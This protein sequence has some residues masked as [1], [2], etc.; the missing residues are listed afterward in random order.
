VLVHSLVGRP[1]NDILSWKVLM[2]TLDDFH[3]SGLELD[4]RGFQILCNGCEKALLASFKLSAEEQEDVLTSIQIVTQEFTQLS[5]AGEKVHP[6]IPTLLH[7]IEGVHLHAY[8][9]VLGF[10]KEHK[11]L[12]D[13]LR[14]MVQHNEALQKIANDTKNGW[15]LILRTIVA[16][17]VFLGRTE[18][19]AEAESLVNGVE[20][21][22]GWPED[23]AA[24]QYIDFRLQD[25]D[26]DKNEPADHERRSYEQD[27]DEPMSEER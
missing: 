19:E 7:S 24:E 10:A 21:W 8:V 15:T 3:R 13:V 9:R 18:F 11:C 5:G 14:W 1:E 17:K 27:D 6:T 25:D 16:C 2:A 22:G 12:L 26:G 4:P 23:A 20:T